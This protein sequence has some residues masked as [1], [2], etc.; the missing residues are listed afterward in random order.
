MFSITREN[1]I[2]P[3]I[4]VGMGLLAA[5]G[6]HLFCNERDEKKAASSIFT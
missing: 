2:N 5:D 4:G 1:T 6:A 3:L